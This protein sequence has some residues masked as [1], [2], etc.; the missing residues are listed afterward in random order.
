MTHPPNSERHT[1]DDLAP[2]KGDDADLDR[3][4]AELQHIHLPRLAEAGYI[5]WDA[6]TQ[7]VRRGPNFNEVAPL[8]QPIDDHSDE[9][10]AGWPE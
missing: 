3:L 5:D 4:K 2:A 6:E 8:L 10:P 9:R 1:S 7:T